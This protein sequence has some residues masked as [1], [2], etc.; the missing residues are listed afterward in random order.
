MDDLN[1]DYQD[2]PYF[3]NVSAGVHD[4]F[5]KDKNGCGVAVLE[6]FVLG[7]PKFFTPNDDLYNNT[8][9]LKGW[10]DLFTQQSRIY[11]YDRYGKLIKQLSPSS[12]GW[13]GT[14]NG[15]KLSTTDFWFTAELVEQDGTIRTLR[16]HFS[17]VR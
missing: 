14:F 7:F 11:I 16:G 1:G 13:D 15:N 5:V 8:W 6:V 2:E 3:S 12:N 4:L 9:N 17:L 10:S